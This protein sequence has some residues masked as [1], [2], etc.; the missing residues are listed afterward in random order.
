[1]PFNLRLLRVFLAVAHRQNITQAAVD[2]A[3]TQP[4]VSRSVRELERQTRATLL[5]RTASGVRLTEA[6][7]ALLTHARVIFAEARAAE[8]DLQALAGLAQ[9]TLRVGGSPTIA[10][11]L[12]PPLLHAFQAHYPGVEMRL[13]SAPSRLIA[14]LLAEREIDVA[15]VETP[16]EDPRLRSA[17]WVEDELVVIAAPSHPLA[18]R[19]TVPPSALVHELLVTR[20]PG[21]GT[22]NTVMGALRTHGVVPQR[23]LEVD[24]AEAIIQLV[25]AGLGFAIVSRYAAADALALGRLAVVDVSGVQI[26]RP[27]MRLSLVTGGESATARAFNGFLDEDGERR[28]APEQVRRSQKRRAQS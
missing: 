23:R 2:L 10:T 24:T 22:Y 19:A 28:V 11:Y 6:G 4:A 5:E 3:L 17:V 7:R 13:T 20:E 9:G 16:V 8:E 12:L 25:A 27:L 18:S 26:R 14:R 1:M 15:L 21:S